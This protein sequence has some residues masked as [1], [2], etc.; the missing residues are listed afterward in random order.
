MFCLCFQAGTRNGEEQ[1]RR[2][3]QGIPTLN[4]SL[5]N[6]GV[7]SLDKLNSRSVNPA[8]V[9]QTVLHYLSNAR[10]LTSYQFVCL[11]MAS[12]RYC[13][14]HVVTNVCETVRIRALTATTRNEAA[15]WAVGSG[16]CNA[17]RAADFGYP[18]QGWAV[19]V[20]ETQELAFTFCGG[21]G[22]R[23]YDVTVPVVWFECR[24]CPRSTARLAWSKT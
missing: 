14:I 15:T 23:G 3:Q 8:L 16:K 9:R 2:D 19:V 20:S 5:P 21:R 13:D 22:L 4:A 7:V 11:G 17:R 1:G 18:L 24:F 10:R 6:G 12:S